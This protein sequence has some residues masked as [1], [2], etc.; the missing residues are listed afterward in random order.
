[1]NVAALV[2]FHACGVGVEKMKEWSRMK[3]SCLMEDC[4]GF[5]MGEGRRE[6]GTG[7]EKGEVLSDE[8]LGRLLGRW[9]VGSE[10]WM[11]PE[12]VL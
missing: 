2:A 4:K 12:R 10:N 11:V 7:K 5:G 6:E 9:G 8:G 3:R 1:M